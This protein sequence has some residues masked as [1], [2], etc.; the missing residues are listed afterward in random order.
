MYSDTHCFACFSRSFTFLY[1]I[2]TEAGSLIA[3]NTRVLL[4]KIKWLPWCFCNNQLKQESPPSGNR[5][6]TVPGRGYPHPVLVGRERVPHPVPDWG[7]GYITP[8]LAG[9]VL[10]PGWGPPP[11][12]LLGPGRGNTPPPSG[13]GTWLGL[14]P[15]WD[16]DLATRVPPSPTHTCENITSRR[17]TY[18]VGK[19]TLSNNCISIEI[20]KKMT[21]RLSADIGYLAF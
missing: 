19:K 13:T 14:P 8:V 3:Y 1:L 10:H 12:L 15:I 6:I 7:W 5:N 4:K 17:I 11:H 21:R 2:R 16:E 9:R 18:A 20:M